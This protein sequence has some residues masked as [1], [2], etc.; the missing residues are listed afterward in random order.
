MSMRDDSAS[1]AEMVDDNSQLQDQICP[2][3]NSLVVRDPA[4]KEFVCNCFGEQEFA[5][6]IA[7]ARNIARNQPM[8]KIESEV[9][10]IKLPPM[11]EPDMEM[12]ESVPTA[13]TAQEQAPMFVAKEALKKMPN[14]P[15]QD[16]IAAWKQQFGKIYTFSFDTDEIYVWR[17]IFRREWQN[18][19]TMEALARDEGK[20]QE[21]FV[22]K[23]VLWPTLG[24][25]EINASRAGMVPTLFQIIM[26]GSGF[27]PI[28]LAVNLIQEL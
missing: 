11:P 15:S 24:P 2:K 27:L 14:A 19:Q 3:C 22:M 23:T 8:T 4:T 18:L 21:H 1:A 9:P 28:D 16:Q 6:Q 10:Q 5:A 26:Q 13:S 12:P 25:V 17:P 20:F 7:A